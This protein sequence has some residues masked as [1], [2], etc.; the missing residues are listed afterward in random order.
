MARRQRSTAFPFQA[1][2]YGLVLSA[3]NGE[4]GF[5]IADAT[6]GHLKAGVSVRGNFEPFHT[7]VFYGPAAINN[8]GTLAFFAIG[9]DGASFGIFTGTGATP[10]PVITHEKFS[11]LGQGVAISDAGAVAFV[12]TPVDG[13]GE[14]IFVGVKGKLRKVAGVDGGPFAGFGFDA[15][16]VSI[17]IDDGGNVAF[18]ARLAAGGA[19]IYTGP[20]A[21]DRIIGTGDAFFG[22]TVTELRFS[23]QAMDAGGNIAFGQRWRMADR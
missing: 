11:Q 18:P 8:A 9:S 22:S 15:G 12:G 3:E 13:T 4:G 21:T 6:D 23:T 1:S 19:G 17:G 10:T 5:V 14:G 16:F 2:D 7:T 20:A